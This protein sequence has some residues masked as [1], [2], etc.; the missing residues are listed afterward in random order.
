MEDCPVHDDLKAHDEWSADE[1]AAFDALPREGTLTPGEENRLVAAL[2]NEGFFRGST[3]VP[4]VLLQLAAAAVLFV[5][6][7]YAGTRMASRH[8]IESL[9]ERTDLS[10]DDR[11]FLLQR[12]G[13]AYVRAANGYANATSSVDSAA[14]E[15]ASQVLMGA[16]HAVARQSLD[17]GVTVQ[18]ATMFNPPAVA[19]QGVRQ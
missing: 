17:G 8:T 5:A 11:V 9:L 13:S 10:L 4:M 15:V 14:V 3:R 1:R 6:G 2:R 7:G 12:A 16:A 19:P 18:L